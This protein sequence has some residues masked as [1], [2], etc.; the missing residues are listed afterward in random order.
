MKPP[1][2]Q[3][4]KGAQHKRVFTS[5]ASPLRFIMQHANATNP[6]FVGGAAARECGPRLSKPPTLS[7]HWPS[8]KHVKAHLSNMRPL[9][10]MKARDG[11]RPSSQIR[12]TAS[13]GRRR[14]SGFTFWFA[15][16]WS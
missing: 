6:K 9:N 5:F 2:T 3:L 16:G 12:W 15:T 11:I 7:R 14:V 8:M 10:L 13:F 4:C 1:N